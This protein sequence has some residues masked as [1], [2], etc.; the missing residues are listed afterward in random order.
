VITTLF[1]LERQKL[2]RSS[3][4]VALQVPVAVGV[5]RVTFRIARSTEI[6]V[7]FENPATIF[8]NF[9]LISMNRSTLNEKVPIGGSAATS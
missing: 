2:Q 1:R 9:K 4:R 5:I 7:I 3:K 6:R 8:Q